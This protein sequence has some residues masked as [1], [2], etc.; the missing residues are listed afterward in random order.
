MHTAGTSTNL[1]SAALPLSLLL[2]LLL[3]L[4]VTPGAL[5]NQ[6][7]VNGTFLLTITARLLVP[8]AGDCGLLSAS[9]PA[10]GLQEE[11]HVG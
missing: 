8:E 5:V 4:L 3:L 1:S 2:L 7:L 10:L 6:Q 11:K 9:L